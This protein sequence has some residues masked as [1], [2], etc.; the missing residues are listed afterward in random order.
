MN[1]KIFWTAALFWLLFY[2]GGFLVD[3]KK[4]NAGER[5]HE[6]MGNVA[7][8]GFLVSGAITFVFALKI[9]WQ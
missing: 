8:V 4:A 2:F 3:W 6:F 5:A 1:E 7:A 9:I